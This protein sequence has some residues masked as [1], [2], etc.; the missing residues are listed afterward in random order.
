MKIKYLGTAAYEGIPSLFC[1][2]RVCRTAMEQGGRELRSRSQ[3]LVNDDLLLDFPADTVWHSQRFHLD[4]TKISD[5][6]V[7][8]SHSDH[9][10]PEDL[11]MAAPGYTH[12]HRALHFHAGESGYGKIKKILDRPHIAEAM[13]A[14]MSVSL[15]EPGRRFYVGENGK[16]SVLPL[17]ANHA[18]DTSPVIYSITDGKK[19]MLY[20]HDSGVFCEATWAGLKEEGK[21]DLVSLDCTGCMQSGWRDGHMS[22]DANLETLERMKK[23]KLI[24]EGTVVVINHFSHNGGRTHEEMV[25]EAEK[26]GIIV[27]YD[28]LEIDF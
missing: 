28:G 13:K 27:S 17:W 23:E 14:V 4:W 12:E 15:V 21:F 25:S 19:R 3:A 1:N 2:C 6:L 18:Q 10:Y 9:L 16:Y 5:C 11:E 8:H 22:F 26:Y 7:T 24:G 20:A